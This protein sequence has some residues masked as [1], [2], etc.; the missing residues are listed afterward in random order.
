MYK[1]LLI[2]FFCSTPGLLLAQKA[3]DP[4][5]QIDTTGKKDLVDVARSVFHINP[6]PDTEKKGKSFYF[7][8]LPVSS[9]VPGGG[10]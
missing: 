10:R 7:S 9:A 1:F 2:I 8:I 6:K 4:S 5:K 3:I